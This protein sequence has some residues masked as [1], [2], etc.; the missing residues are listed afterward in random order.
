MF[1]GRNG[2][3]GLAEWFGSGRG[4]AILSCIHD[5]RRKSMGFLRSL[6]GYIYAA[7]ISTCFI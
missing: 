1:L 2:S 5:S 6:E 4:Q 3:A 7:M